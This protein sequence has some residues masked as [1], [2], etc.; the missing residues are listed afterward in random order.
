M[1]MS[2]T[3][4][5]GQEIVQRGQAWYDRQIRSEVEAGNRG[6]FLV[7]NIETG[8]YGMDADDIA[9]SKRARLRFPTAPLFSMRIG[10]GA[11][12]RLGKVAAS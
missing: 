11:T 3:R 2:H 4:S 12:Y 9:A 7:I 8:D 5:A 1:A 6:K 10:S